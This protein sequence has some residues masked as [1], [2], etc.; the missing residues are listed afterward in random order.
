MKPLL[1]K[2]NIR[3]GQTFSPTLFIHGK[4]NEEDFLL[5]KKSFETVG[6]SVDHPINKA[7]LLQE[8]IEFVFADFNA[9]SH[10]QDTMLELF[11]LRCWKG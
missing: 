1:N 8:A 7:N 6:I 11:L 4:I 10:V 2:L 9:I 3:Q 5:I